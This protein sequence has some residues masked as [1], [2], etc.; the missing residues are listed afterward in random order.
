MPQDELEQV[1]GPIKVFK[2]NFFRAGLEVYYDDEN[3]S[4]WWTGR[5]MILVTFKDGRVS[6][7]T[8]ETLEPTSMRRFLAWWDSRT[9][10][11]EL[12]LE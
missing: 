4:S 3:M 6:R 12:I 8:Y 11:P 10:D 2:G 7:A 1:L 9:R 5:G